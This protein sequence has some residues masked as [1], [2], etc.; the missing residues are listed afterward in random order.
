[1]LRGPVTARAGTS[2]Y[3]YLP[4]E[5]RLTCGVAQSPG[6]VYTHGSVHRCSDKSATCATRVQP[7]ITAPARPSGDRGQTLASNTYA[8]RWDASLRPRTSRLKV[9]PSC[10]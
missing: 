5:G 10:G 9:K 6:R 1:M 4:V 8:S 3:F 7:K 2:I